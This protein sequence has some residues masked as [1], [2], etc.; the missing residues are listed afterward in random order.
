MIRRYEAM[1]V[2]SHGES[3]FPAW[4]HNLSLRQ[5]PAAVVEAHAL[6]SVKFPPISYTPALPRQLVEG[7]AISDVQLEVVALAG[8]R[9]NLTLNGVRSGFLLG[10]GTG[11]GKGRTIAAVIYDNWLHGRRKAVWVTVSNDLYHDAIRDLAAVGAHALIKKVLQYPKESD[12]LEVSE[13]IVFTSYSALSRGWQRG[14]RLQ[15]WLGQHSNPT[16]E[17][18]RYPCRTGV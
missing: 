11:M 12:E 9:H 4:F 3:Q 15:H 2:G 1:S 18:E 6:A 8:Q 10:D 5:H 17:P 16:A 13:G 14:L 7:G